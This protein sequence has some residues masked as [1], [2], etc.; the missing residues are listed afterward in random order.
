MPMAISSILLDFE[1]RGDR[2]LE[3]DVQWSRVKINTV[4]P[5]GERVYIDIDPTTYHF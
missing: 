4:N 3:L 2:V 1:T 5:A